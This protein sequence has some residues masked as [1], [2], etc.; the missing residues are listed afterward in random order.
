MNRINLLGNKKTRVENLVVLS[1][2][3]DS[4]RIKFDFFLETRD[5]ELKVDL[6]RGTW[7]YHGWE[8]LE[9]GTNRPIVSN[10]RQGIIGVYDRNN[11]NHH[12]AWAQAA[13]EAVEDLH[14]AR[15]S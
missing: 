9:I 2:K 1:Y 5:A 10:D 12:T 4:N 13:L 15:E 8:N 11:L 7:T 14:S 3:P 6:N